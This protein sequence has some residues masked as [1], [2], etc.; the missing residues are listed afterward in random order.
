MVNINSTQTEL[1]N[2][3]IEDSKISLLAIA[4]ETGLS[5]STLSRRTKGHGQWTTTEIYL[6]ANAIRVPFMALVP[7]E[8]V[9]AELATA[10]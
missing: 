5:Y 8:L 4:N 7:V 10:S 6:I 1:V 9:P 3:A 2:R